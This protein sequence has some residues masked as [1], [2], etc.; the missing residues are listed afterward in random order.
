MLSPQLKPTSPVESTELIMHTALSPL[1]CQ[2]RTCD[3]VWRYLV[4][5]PLRERYGHLVETVMF[6][7]H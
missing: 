2:L 4:D 3:S 5:M 1:S 6:R 7:I